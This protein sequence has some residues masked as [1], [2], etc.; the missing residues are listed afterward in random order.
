MSDAS[1]LE[2]PRL[3]R[4]EP[5][6]NYLRPALLDGR[7]FSDRNEDMTHEENDSGQAIFFR[8]PCRSAG[9]ETP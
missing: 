4:C 5:T 8:I 2:T 1:V 7:T 9:N 6:F 3:S